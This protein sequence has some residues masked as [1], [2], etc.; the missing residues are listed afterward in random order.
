MSSPKP[1]SNGGFQAEEEVVRKG[2]GQGF[3]RLSSLMGQLQLLSP[4]KSL[5]MIL[6]PMVSP[7]WAL[8]LPRKNERKGREGGRR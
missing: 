2:K 1:K 7:H 3:P 6:L 8:A 4:G 5:S